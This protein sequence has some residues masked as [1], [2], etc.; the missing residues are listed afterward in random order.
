MLVIVKRPQLKVGDQIKWRPQNKIAKLEK[1]YKKLCTGTVTAVHDD[2]YT[3]LPDH[4][5]IPGAL[6][7][8]TETFVTAQQVI[9]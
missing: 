9:K 8:M 6:M 5:T 1:T 7:Y 2:C 3:V 4:R